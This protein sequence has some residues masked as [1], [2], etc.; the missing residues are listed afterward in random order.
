[1]ILRRLDD[2]MESKKQD[3]LLLYFKYQGNTELL[4]KQSIQEHLDWFDKHAVS[5]EQVIDFKNNRDYGDI[6]Y[7]I[8]FDGTDD[9]R[10]TEYSQKFEDDKFISLKP[11]EYQMYL[12]NFVSWYINGGDLHFEGNSR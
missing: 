3:V 2:L 8:N 11:D 5:Y 10:I 6:C 9:A 12:Y 4:P 1:M 7:C